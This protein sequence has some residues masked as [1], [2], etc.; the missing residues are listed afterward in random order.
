[1]PFSIPKDIVI[2]NKA[3]TLLIPYHKLEDLTLLA[4]ASIKSFNFLQSS[5][6]FVEYLSLE[7]LNSC[8][9]GISRL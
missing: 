1:M 4:T 3:E 9:R 8:E 2:K 7:H 5:H 6:L